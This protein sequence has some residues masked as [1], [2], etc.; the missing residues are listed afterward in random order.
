MDSTGNCI[1]RFT[2]RR[3]VDMDAGTAGHSGSL[4]FSTD[5]AN[6][7]KLSQDADMESA[8]SDFEESIV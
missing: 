7:K 3:D 8:V 2:R 5:V 4:S 1:V 6:K